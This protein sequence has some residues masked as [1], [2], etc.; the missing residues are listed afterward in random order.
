MS[1]RKDQYPSNAWYKFEH[2]LC[3][4]PTTRPE[5]NKGSTQYLIK[6]FN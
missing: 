2:I 6:Y 5:R 1:R 3:E 4:R